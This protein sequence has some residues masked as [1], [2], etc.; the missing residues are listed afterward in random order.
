MKEK[1]AQLLALPVLIFLMTITL[2][3]YW[4][5][6]AGPFLFDDFPNIEPL[7][8]FGGVTD[9]Q[10][11][12]RFVFGNNSGPTGRPV[13]MATFLLDDS[14]WPSPAFGFK[15]TN[16]MFHLLCGMAIGLVIFR[17]LRNELGYGSGVAAAIALAVLGLWLMHPINVSTVLY[18]VQRMAILS[19]FFSL[20][21][22]YFYFVF[23]EAF[24]NK[25]TATQYIALM[26]SILFL[27]LGVF[28]KENAL[29][30]PVFL[31][32]LEVYFFKKPVSEP[33]RK[34]VLSRTIPLGI[35]VIV[36]LYLSSGWWGGGYQSRDFVVWER[37]LFQFPIV[38]DY[39]LKIIAPVSSAFNLF[40]G[41]Y[42]DIQVG[43]FGYVDALRSF[44]SL[45]LLALLCVSLR[46]RWLV[47]AFGL[48]WFF[49]FHAIESSIWPLEPY[50][51]H[52]N[53]LPGIGLILVFV[54][55]VKES[56]AYL[57]KGQA[58]ASIALMSVFFYLV[59]VTFFLNLTWAD[60]DNLYLKW[61][62]DEPSSARAKV[63]YAK[64][65]ENKGFPE[66]ALEGIDRAI[67]L[68]PR[69][70]G[71]HLRKL[72]LICRYK[73]DADV[74]SVLVK[75]Q[76]ADKFDFGVTH[77]VKQLLSLERNSLGEF[78][79]GSSSP[80]SPLFIFRTVE[81]AQ[82]M[83]WNSRRGALFYSL[84]SDYYA[85]LGRLN[86][87]VVA[88]ERAASYTPTVDLHVKTAVMLA[89][90]ELYK[91]ALEKLKLAAVADGKRPFRYPSRLEEIDRLQA[92]FIRLQSNKLNDGEA[93][94]IHDQ[95]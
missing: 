48:S 61:E 22:V 93:S 23:R 42:A 46:K 7:G 73:L 92:K 10:S 45:F 43:S 1:V 30:V 86:E 90:A 31:L 33:L 78:C 40:N 27:L 38:G 41:D 72:D 79:V 29:L 24:F 54:V 89:S 51:E 67:L 75:V 25:R 74:E 18:V 52:R 8:Y 85:S 47:V 53:Y 59:F 87:A 28:S 66:N 14:G 5:G 35:M 3:V 65:V 56:S 44:V 88:I 76:Q 68:E 34:L 70:L 9:S 83:R 15:Y 12:L 32:F 71:L 6:L 84:K 4:P 64:S 94:I 77:A 69:S 55:A 17:L 19:A 36:G 21:S 62:M 16:L 82:S 49:I 13:A 11:A 2:I 20:F 95:N 63:A 60:S 26:L 91:S 81:Q 50:F 39:I 80:I 58:S 57:F 37:V